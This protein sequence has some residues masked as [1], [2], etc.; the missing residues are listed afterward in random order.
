MPRCTTVYMFSFNFA[1]TFAL[2]T[3]ALYVQMSLGT[4]AEATQPVCPPQG[5]YITTLG[6]LSV[7]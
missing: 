2:R 3:L 1:L 4:A 5:S 7:V 6:G